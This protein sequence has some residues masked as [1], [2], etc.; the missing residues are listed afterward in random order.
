M[1]R[2]EHREA[3]TAFRAAREAVLRGRLPS[4]RDLWTLIVASCCDDEASLETQG[5]CEQ[6]AAYLAHLTTLVTSELRDD[7]D[8]GAQNRKTS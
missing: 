2:P 1:T 5:E 7:A 6:S 3:L 8:E 4:A